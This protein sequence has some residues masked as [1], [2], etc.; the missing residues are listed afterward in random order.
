MRCKG[1]SRPQHNC[2]SPEAPRFA[3]ND[4]PN[5]IWP[6]P[7][8]TGKDYSINLTLSHPFIRRKI[9]CNL[10]G[11]IDPSPLQ[12]CFVKREAG[13]LLSAYVVLPCRHTGG[14]TAV[15][16][17]CVSFSTL[18]TVKTDFC[19]S[20]FLLLFWNSTLPSLVLGERTL[21]RDLWIRT[22]NSSSTC[23]LC[24]GSY[25]CPCFFGSNSITPS[26]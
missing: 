13:G 26:L 12:R 21:N 6:N 3:E 10:S 15:L 19:W 24:F 14:F 9:W 2:G 5:L 11:Q 8:R 7:I 22:F 16:R 4:L 1:C 20:L 17:C 25:F 23:K 18:Q